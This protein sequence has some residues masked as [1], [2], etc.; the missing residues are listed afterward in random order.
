MPEIK[1]FAD[2]YHII[3][4]C[5]TAGIIVGIT[6]F[7]LLAKTVIDY[8]NTLNSRIENLENEVIELQTICGQEEQETSE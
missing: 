5:L 7:Y 4:A 6:T 2:Y 1:D 3:I 8:L